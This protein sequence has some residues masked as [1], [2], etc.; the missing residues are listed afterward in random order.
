ME[1]PGL[2]FREG[3]APDCERIALSSGS[4]LQEFFNF[5]LLNNSAL[6][7]SALDNILCCTL[8]DQVNPFGDD[9]G[10][11]HAFMRHHL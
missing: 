2:E 10:R 11:K 3:A 6:V 9:E 8:S 7:R 5:L 1:P 4:A